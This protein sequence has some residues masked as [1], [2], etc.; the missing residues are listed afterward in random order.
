MADLVAADVTVTANPLDFTIVGRHRR[1]LAKITFGDGAKT[2][3]ASGIPLPAIGNFGMVRNLD[4]LILH[5]A[6]D[7]HGIVWKW[8][9]ENHKL[10]GY[11]QGVT[12]SAAGGA[13]V[14]DYALNPTGDALTSDAS[15]SLANSAGAGT[16]YL[17]KLK[18]MG[19]EPAA[20][21]ARQ[22]VPAQTLYCEVVGW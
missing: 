12:V 6:D 3:P 15:L 17:G 8:D 11:I 4:A 22:A 13:T 1:G 18:E 21:G 16:Y 10:R 9:K 7:A 14:D 5:D 2:Y 19:V 20:A